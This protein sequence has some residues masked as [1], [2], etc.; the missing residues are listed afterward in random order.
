[1]KLKI[2]K[3]NFSIEKEIYNSAHPIKIKD[4]EEITVLGNRGVW[5]NRDEVN[6][7][8][9]PIPIS[10]YRLNDDLTPG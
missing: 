6:N 3:M 8:R 2:L 5:A 1:L 9:G 7:W 4:D 10:D